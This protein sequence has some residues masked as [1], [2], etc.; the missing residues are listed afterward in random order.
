MPAV[1]VYHGFLS[2]AV[3]GRSDAGIE[4]TSS[5]FSHF[6]VPYKSS[7]PGLMLSNEKRQRHTMLVDDVSFLA[8][9]T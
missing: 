2:S 8:T 7:G 9:Q 4:T 1:V 6:G 5:S 3:G